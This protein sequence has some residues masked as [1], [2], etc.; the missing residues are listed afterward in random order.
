MKNAFLL[1]LLIFGIN[2]AANAQFGGQILDNLKRKTSDKIDE[3]I[4]KVADKTE[5]KVTQKA[6]K[7]TGSS[8]TP[9]GSQS[10]PEEEE[11]AAINTTRSN[12]STVKTKE[13]TPFTNNKR[14][15]T[16]LVFSETTYD[17]EPNPNPIL[18][19]IGTTLQQKLKGEKLLIKIYQRTSG[20]DAAKAE[21]EYMAIKMYLVNRY[22]LNEDRIYFVTPTTKKAGTN[23]TIEFILVPESFLYD[24]VAKY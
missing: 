4:D 10:A 11:V 3:V 2:H 13:G 17:F 20:D 22:D 23:R 7:K 6:K 9:S 12:V 24:D 8:S 5:E 21:E 19:G 16:N 14:V 15:V 18:N 1:L